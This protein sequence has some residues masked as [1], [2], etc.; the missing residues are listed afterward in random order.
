MK[1]KEN[2][3]VIFTWSS[4][5]IYD[6]SNFIPHKEYTILEARFDSYGFPYYT[7]ETENNRHKMVYENHLILSKRIIRNNI[8]EEI[9]K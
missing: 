9:L 6:Y 3:I 1:F 8:I 4:Y 7:L 5:H 2:D